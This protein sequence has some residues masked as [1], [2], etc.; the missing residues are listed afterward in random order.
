MIPGK[1]WSTGFAGGENPAGRPHGLAGVPAAPTIGTPKKVVVETGSPPVAIE[2]YCSANFGPRS[3]CQKIEAVLRR[4]PTP[5]G[6]GSA[7]VAPSSENSPTFANTSTP[8]S[9][10]CV[11]D[12]SQS[13]RVGAPGPPPGPEPHAAPGRPDAQGRGRGGGGGRGAGK[14]GGSGGG[15]VARGWAD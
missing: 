1:G 4:A 7:A 11:F 14:S 6:A 8:E 10:S 5:A 12:G 9:G 3:R 15:G 2:A 13:S